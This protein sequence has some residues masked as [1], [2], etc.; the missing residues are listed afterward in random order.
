[1]NINTF[2]A[3]EHTGVHLQGRCYTQGELTVGPSN[4]TFIYKTPLTNYSRVILL[5][6]MKYDTSML[7]DLIMTKKKTDWVGRY[8]T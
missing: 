1:M 8:F 5:S 4:L 3:E 6:N 2:P 7:V